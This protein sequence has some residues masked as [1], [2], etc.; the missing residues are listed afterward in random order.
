MLLLY[1]DWHSGIVTSKLVFVG[2]TKYQHS[3]H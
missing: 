2:M 3:L 1:A